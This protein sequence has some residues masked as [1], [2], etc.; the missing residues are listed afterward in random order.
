MRTMSI[1]I[2]LLAFTACGTAPR[3]ASEP[4]PLVTSVIG[5]A[6]HEPGAATENISTEEMEAAIAS[7]TVLILDTRPRRE[8]A[9]SHIPGALN[10][11][12]KPGTSKALYV[13]DVA[14]IGR[15]AGG[16]K[17]KPLV[18]YCN[19]P[20]CGKAKRISEELVRD[21]FTSVRRYQLGAPVWRAL[22]KLMVIEA[23]AIPYVMTDP[24]AVFIDAR[25]AAEFGRGSLDGARNIPRDSLTEGKD[26]PAIRAA[27]EDGTLPMHDH[28]TRVIVFGRDAAQARAVAQVLTH[29]AF[30]NVAVFEGTYDEFMRAARP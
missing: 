30:H 25:A 29:E 17:Q 7:G 14:E 1:A 18:I 24:T 23:E 6:L 11:A 12:P 8:W 16:D 4:A 21:G 5:A 26:S 13:S 2:L 19:G 9:I 22:G 15:L 10:V 27:K 20:F 3:A 28:N